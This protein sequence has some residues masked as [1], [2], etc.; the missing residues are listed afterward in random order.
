M[1]VEQQFKSLD[2]EDKEKLRNI[3]QTALDVQN[4]SNLSG[5]IHSFSKVMTELWD[6]ATS[7]NKGTDWVNTHPVS[8]LFASKIDSLCGG[9]DDNFHNAYMQITDWLEKNNA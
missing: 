1:L 2:E 8:V 9:S 7:L 4:A 3:C 5:V 6:I